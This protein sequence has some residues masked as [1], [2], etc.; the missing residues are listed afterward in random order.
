MMHADRVLIGNPHEQGPHRD[1]LLSDR[2]GFTGGGDTE[3][4]SEG[5]RTDLAIW[6]AAAEVT[7]GPGSTPSRSVLTLS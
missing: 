7:T 5:S 6:L 4:G 1:I 3:V 2:P